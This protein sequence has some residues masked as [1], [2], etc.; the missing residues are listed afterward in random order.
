MARKPGR[1][2]ERHLLSYVI[3][4]MMLGALAVTFLPEDLLTFSAFVIPPVT[5]A[6][7]LSAAWKRASVSTH[8]LLM[9]TGAVIVIVCLILGG[10]IFNT[11]RCR[12]NA[13]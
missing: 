11:K 5:T 8:N 2:N 12:V 3:L 4:N 10:F 7:S 9:A 6:L 13:H 1:K